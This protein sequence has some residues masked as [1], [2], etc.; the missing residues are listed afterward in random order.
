MTAHEKSAPCADSPERKGDVDEHEDV[1]DRDGHD[2]AVRLALQL[3]LR[4]KKARGQ[5]Y[6][7]KNIFTG[8]NG[9]NFGNF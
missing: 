5:C 3:V 1:R 2:V 9:E 7:F 8:K 6:G 4:H